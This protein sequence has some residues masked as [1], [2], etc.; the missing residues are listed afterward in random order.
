MVEQFGLVTIW[1]F[2]PRSRCWRG[3]DLQVIGVDLGHQ[4]RNIG[5]HAVVARVGDDDVAGLR[6]K[7]ARFPW[8]PRH[9]SRR[10]PGAARCRACIR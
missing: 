7:R 2:Q 5:L 10:T 3:N 4:Q 8:R 6:R 1:P 9:P